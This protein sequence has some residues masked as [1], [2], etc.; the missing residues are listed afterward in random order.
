MTCDMSHVI[1]DSRHV[2]HDFFLKKSAKKCNNKTMLKSAQK[3]RKVSKRQDFIVSV[4]LLAHAERVGVSR[5]RDL[6]KN[7]L[8]ILKCFNVAYDSVSD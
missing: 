3:C 4:L 2:T 6:K 8:Q 5:M 7:T 1:C